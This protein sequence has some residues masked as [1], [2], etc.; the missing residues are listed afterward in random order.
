MR[1][2]SRLDERPIGAT[3]SAI[4]P[5]LDR[6]PDPR[7]SSPAAQTQAGGSGY[8]SPKFH[9]LPALRLRW[10]AI[11]T[12]RDVVARLTAPVLLRDPIGAS[13]AEAARLQ[14]AVPLVCG[15]VSGRQSELVS[16]MSLAA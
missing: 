10:Q 5:H 14:P 15:L 3:G 16:S 4:L 2:A 9:L 13:A 6:G 1:H 7:Q 8:L 11:G 12:A